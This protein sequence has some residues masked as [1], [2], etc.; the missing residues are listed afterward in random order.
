[1][2]QQPVVKRITSYL[3]SYWLINAPTEGI[4]V[5]PVDDYLNYK[6]SKLS[7]RNQWTSVSIQ[8]SLPTKGGGALIIFRIRVNNIA[9]TSEVKLT[10]PADVILRFSS[11]TF[12]YQWYDP[13]MIFQ[14][15]ASSDIRPDSAWH[16]IALAL[17][18]NSVTLLENGNFKFNWK[19][20]VADFVNPRFDMQ[21]LDV[22]GSL[23]ID[24]DDVVAIPPNANNNDTD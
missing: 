5:A 23:N 22:G 14:T 17:T 15:L 19:H 16:T 8:N 7:K 1:M 6:V 2:A 12:N 3:P 21:I 18:S 4:Q 11:N 13:N 10:L 24:I 20:N 9:D